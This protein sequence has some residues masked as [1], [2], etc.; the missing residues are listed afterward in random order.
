MNEIKEILSKLWKA[1]IKLALS[2][3]TLDEKVAEK[4]NNLNE[5]VKS[6]DEIDNKEEEVK[7]EK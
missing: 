3:T 4:V 7:E 2:K 5:K 6:I 1:I